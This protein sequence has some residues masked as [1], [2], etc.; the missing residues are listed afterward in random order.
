MSVIVFVLDGLRNSSPLE[1]RPSPVLPSLTEL[2][3]TGLLP[4]VSIDG[5]SGEKP[6]GVVISPCRGENGGI[7][8][9]CGVIDARDE[10][11]A[12]ITKP[13]WTWI[14]ARIA[15]MHSND[16]CFSTHHA[17]NSPPPACSCS[18]RRYSQFSSSSPF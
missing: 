6:M 15:S 7:M 8:T 13:W 17:A 11:A 4:F 2:I 5:C 16:T 14:T 3:R 18:S 10:Y 12:G 9:G 1:G